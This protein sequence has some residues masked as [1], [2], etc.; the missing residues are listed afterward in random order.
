[1][2]KTSKA[3]R[4]YFSY[5]DYQRAFFPKTKDRHSTLE[6]PA[7]IGTEL[8]RRALRKLRLTIS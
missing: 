6:D 4:K 3:S 1:M 8:A 2:P 7:K 5:E